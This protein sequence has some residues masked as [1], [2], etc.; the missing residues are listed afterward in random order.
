MPH[1]IRPLAPVLAAVVLLAGLPAAATA[2]PAACD[3]ACLR[4]VLDRYMAAVFKHDPAAAPLSPALK[5]TLNAAP[6][7]WGAVSY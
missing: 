6:L 1:L 5:S 7:G 4:G 2:A 3:R